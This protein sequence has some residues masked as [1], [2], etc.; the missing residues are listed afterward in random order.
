MLFIS[1]KKKLSPWISLTVTSK[2]CRNVQNF[3]LILS[4]LLTLVFAGI[5]FLSKNMNILNLKL[6]K[7]S[8]QIYIFSFSFCKLIN[9]IIWIRNPKK[10]KRKRKERKRYVQV[11]P[12]SFGKETKN[13]KRKSDPFGLVFIFVQ[14]HFSGQPNTAGM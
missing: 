12:F 3:I 4:S 13:S 8:D 2:P 14:I 11:Q 9:P 1:L 7:L 6:I 10:E 5:F